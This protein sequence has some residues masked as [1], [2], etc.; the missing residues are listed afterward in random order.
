MTN[1]HQRTDFAQM[2]QQLYA[3]RQ[4]V[5]MLGD[6]SEASQLREQR[7]QSI[8]QSIQEVEANI[9]D[10]MITEQRLRQNA[11]QFRL[12]V[13]SVG[14]Y[15]I[16]MLDPYGKI[17]SWNRGAHLIKGYATDEIIGKHFSIFYTSEDL[18]VSRPQFA[19]E[20]AQTQGVFRD[21]GWRVRKGGER[22][23][24]H[25]TL[26]ALYDEDGLLR[27][28]AKVTHDLTQRRTTEQA[29]K[30]QELQLAYEQAARE[31]AEELARLRDTFL[32]AVAHEFRTPITAIL[33]Y[34]EL[35]RYALPQLELPEQLKK[36]VHIIS[37][38]AK[39]LER[40]AG[41]VLTSTRLESG[42]LQLEIAPFDAALTV[43]A[44][45]EELQ[46]ISH[47]ATIHFTAS[48]QGYLVNGSEAH[49][50]QAIYNIIQNAIKY[51]P[52]QS[53][54]Y[55]DLW[56]QDGNIVLKVE[57]NGIGIAEKDLPHIGERFYR[58]SNGERLTK[59]G[60]GIGL[61]LVKEFISLQNGRIEIASVEGEGT[62]VHIY[63]PAFHEEALHLER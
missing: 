60:L 5:E 45:V 41:M 56:E 32:S 51:S 43:A 1:V 27:G 17:I 44:I 24:A 55:V 2:Q 16:F 18:A 22:F 53:D 11:E 54:V 47:E 12:L 46:L 57:D 7:L 9:Q 28:F 15:A 33:G 35:F 8:R 40:L 4:S 37:L 39:R 58:A 63:L 48:D 26:T 49:F 42:S 19:L 50:E 20:A 30:Q 25:V 52:P 59:N 13:T 31:R 6:A 61:Y 10:A 23:W 21:E 62:T 34:T 3:L 14:D 38:Q 29:L 36:A